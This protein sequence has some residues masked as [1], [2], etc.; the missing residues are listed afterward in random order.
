[1]AFRM[2][3]SET[4]TKLA[5]TTVE[6]AKDI[7]TKTGVH[8]GFLQNGSMTIAANKAWLEE[9]KQIHTVSQYNHMLC[10]Y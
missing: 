4:T 1:M 5:A 2:R 10:Y 3:Q 9:C 8:T 7:E 6:V